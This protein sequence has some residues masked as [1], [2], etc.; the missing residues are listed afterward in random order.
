MNPFCKAQLRRTI[1][2]LL[3]F[4]PFV[5]VNCYKICVTS[6][7]ESKVMKVLLKLCFYRQRRGELLWRPARAA[8]TQSTHDT[9]TKHESTTNKSVAFTYTDT[10]ALTHCRAYF[11]FPPNVIFSVFFFCAS[12]NKRHLYV[13][14]WSDQF[15]YESMSTS[16]SAPV[17][18]EMPSW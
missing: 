15:V 17:C 1:L 16:F 3:L 12:L 5:W 10:T 8:E 14:K 11:F 18:V 7:G 2:L 13:S 4:F 9:H 6:N